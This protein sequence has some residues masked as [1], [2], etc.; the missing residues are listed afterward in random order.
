LA[1]QHG[2]GRGEIALGLDAGAVV[3]KFEAAG[4]PAGKRQIEAQGRKDFFERALAILDP[5]GPAALSDREPE[6]TGKLRVPDP[7]DSRGFSAGDLD[8]PRA[9]GRLKPAERARGQGEVD[10]H[11]RH[12][13][14]AEDLDIR[15]PPAADLGKGERHPEGQGR[16]SAAARDIG[17]VPADFDLSLAADIQPP[18]DPHH[19]EIRLDS[20]RGKHDLLGMVPMKAERPPERESA[21][22]FIRGLVPEFALDLESLRKQRELPPD[23]GEDRPGNSDFLDQGIDVNAPDPAGEPAAAEREIQRL[24]RRPRLGNL[25]VDFSDPGGKSE[26][27]GNAADRLAGEGHVPAFKIRGQARLPRFAADEPGRPGDPARPVERQV[28]GVGDESDGPPDGRLDVD[29][30]ILRMDQRS[31]GLDEKVRMMHRQPPENQFVAPRLKVHVRTPLK[32]D[33]RS[34]ER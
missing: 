12:V 16:E 2:P 24:H 21:V 1:V 25:E 14:G 23:R 34:P 5:A 26:I 3:V 15:S 18:V 9:L 19:R 32:G 27:A 17:H 7:D 6:K 8:D 29:D 31:P 4:D 11:F 13:P 30:G 22:P 20:L 28:E 33:G 10:L